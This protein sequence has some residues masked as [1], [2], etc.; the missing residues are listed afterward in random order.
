MPQPFERSTISF[1]V[2]LWMEATPEQGE[3]QWRGQ[4]EHI[5]TGRTAYFQVPAALLAFFTEHI[6]ELGWQEIGMG[7]AS[8]QEEEGEEGH[9]N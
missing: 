2:R 3:P 1:V 9:E 5:G 6:R 4:I 7:Q 8:S